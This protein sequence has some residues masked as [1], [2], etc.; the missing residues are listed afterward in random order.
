[1]YISD[2]TNAFVTKIQILMQKHVFLKKITVL[3]KKTFFSIKNVFYKK[4]VF[5]QNLKKNVFFPSLIP[6]N[7]NIS[8]DGNTITHK[9]ELANVFYK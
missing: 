6:P 2:K 4:N 9:I 8:L 3:R 5:F 1:M 7:E